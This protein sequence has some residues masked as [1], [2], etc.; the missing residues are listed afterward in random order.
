MKE[1]LNKDLGAG[2][3]RVCYE[4][5]DYVLWRSFVN[6]NCVYNSVKCN[7][8]HVFAANTVLFRYKDVDAFVLVCN[9]VQEVRSCLWRILYVCCEYMIR[10]FV[11]SNIRFTDLW[12][13]NWYILIIYYYITTLYMWIILWRQKLCR[14]KIRCKVKMKQLAIPRDVK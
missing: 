5:I 1:L 8:I 13:V 2:N 10:V 3:R 12:R 4:T 9:W 7:G 14:N 6:F 11:V